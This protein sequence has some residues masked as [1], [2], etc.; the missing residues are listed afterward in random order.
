MK[1]F[2]SKNYFVLVTIAFYLEQFRVS[3]HPQQL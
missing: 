2:E 3:L 1:L